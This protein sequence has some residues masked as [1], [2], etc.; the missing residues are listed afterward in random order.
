MRLWDLS[1]LIYGEATLRSLLTAAG[2]N[3]GPVTDRL[4]KNP[5][6]VR[7]QSIFIQVIATVYVLSMM[8]LPIMSVARLRSGSTHSWNLLISSVATTT[9]FLVQIGY[10]L[11]LTVLAVSELL[12]EDLYVWPQTLPLASGGLARLRLLSLLRGLLLPICFVAVAYPVAMT[13]LSRSPA[14]AGV[15]VLTAAVHFPLT[16]A[17]VVLAGQRLHRTLRGHGG[18]SRGAQAARMITM[19]AYGLG[20]LVVV[21]V[22]QIAI[23]VLTRLYDS[24]HLAPTVSRTLLLAL[25]ALPLPSAPASLTMLLAGSAAGFSADV[26][27]YPAIL[28]SAGYFGAAALLTGAALRILGRAE[29]RTAAAGAASAPVSTALRVSTPSRAFLRQLWLAASRETQ[30]LLFLVFP[31]LL[32]TISVAGFAVSE[33]PRVFVVY[34]GSVTASVFGTWMLVQGLTR[35]ETGTGQ[36]VAALPVRERDRV[37]PRLVIAPLLACAGALLAAL[38]FL[39]GKDLVTG[40][41]LGL[42]PAVTGP[43]GL[44]LK[45][46]LFGRMRAGRTKRRLVLD[47][48]HPEY[49]TQKWIA[50]LATMA[51]VTALLMG[52]RHLLT[53]ATPFPLGDLLFAALLIVS[54][55]GLAL[56]SRRIFP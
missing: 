54:V 11:M 14:V 30:M 20:T 38:V 27:L 6:Y 56:L 16:L 1:K 8:T 44:L 35:Q 15:A 49:G 53:V 7:R 37:F 51:A 42:V 46:A 33:A 48:V 47:E 2:S 29:A 10:V 50:V 36:L 32:P 45:M 13:A 40:L 52:I 17:L 21:F 25:S 23:N 5:G 28:G 22:M 24:P 19:L 18:A 12:D 43:A 3:P 39:R 4:T 31:L 41:V 55:G 9:F 34:F 26:P